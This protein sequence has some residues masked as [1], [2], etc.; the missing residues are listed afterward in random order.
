MADD[1]HARPV[2]LDPDEVA[3]GAVGYDAAKLGLAWVTA[4]PRAR[5]GASKCARELREMGMESE[6]GHDTLAHFLF[7]NAAGPASSG[8][9]QVE[10]WPYTGGGCSACQA[11]LVARMLNS[12]SSPLLI[13]LMGWAAKNGAAGSWQGQVQCTYPLSSRRRL[14][15]PGAAKICVAATVRAAPLGSM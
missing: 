2:Q 11:T 7:A 8:W 3:A 13:L 6:K 1:D 4:S 15:R 10:I 5:E 14:T 9:D 12:L